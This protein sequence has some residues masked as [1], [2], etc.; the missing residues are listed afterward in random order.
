[1]NKLIIFDGE[2]VLCSNTVHW[3]LKRDKKGVFYFT[4]RNSKK[5]G[6]L[7]QKY[8]IEFPDSIV[9]LCDGKIHTQSDAVIKIVTDLGGFYKLA[10]LL[11]L[12]PK[13]L[14]NLVYKIISKNR[15]RW[16]GKREHC[17]VPSIK[18][19]LKFI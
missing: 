6:E 7:A 5:S 11:F 10:K 19:R 13:P 17:F 12:F 4:Q 15:Y 2:C 9:Y 16:F 14:R 3:L 18:D 8:S 1:M